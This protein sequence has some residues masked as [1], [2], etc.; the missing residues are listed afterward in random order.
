[1]IG[2]LT[3]SDVDQN[4]VLAFNQLYTNQQINSTTPSAS[5]LYYDVRYNAATVVLQA[6][7]DYYRGQLLLLAQA[8]AENAHSSILPQ[9]ISLAGY[10][11]PAATITEANRAVQQAA[12]ATQQAQGFVPQPFDMDS[13]FMDVPNNL[14][15]YAIISPPNV[16]NV[17]WVNALNDTE[18]SGWRL[19]LEA[20]LGVL[21]TRLVAGG[22]SWNDG[23]AQFGFSGYVVDGDDGFYVRM[24]NSE[25]TTAAYWFDLATG[26]VNYYN[27]S[28]NYYIAVRD[29]N[30]ET[31]IYGDTAYRRVTQ[32]GI[33]L[34]GDTLIA[35]EN[36]GQMTCQVDN[37][38]QSNPVD[39]SSLVYWTTSDPTVV[40]VSNSPGTLGKLQWI[41]QGG[42]ATITAN[43][44][45]GPGL[46]LTGS[47][48][49]T[50][51]ATSAS[52]TS[53]WLA[54][55]NT[56]YQINPQAQQ[57]YLTGVY[58]DGTIADL[59]QLPGVTFSVTPNA[60]SFNTQGTLGVL[61]YDQPIS[62]SNAAA[63]VTASYQGLSATGRIQ[64]AV[65]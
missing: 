23:L 4:I 64:L 36:G 28:N 46:N 54:P 37:T 17:S 47:V 10:T 12:Q 11:Q 25:G 40:T 35:V 51:T 62:S 8:L 65:P 58:S 63:T 19:P 61:N 49:V 14:M 50:N 34:P 48:S 39:I 13:L 32:S 6:Q 15:W 45:Q 29:V 43:Y 22:R 27:F 31:Y 52:L 56:Q 42:T 59:T 53:V 44:Y 33:Q 26:N 20:E 7:L 16:D 18:Y 30:T 55:Y 2:T 1:M 9:D 24:G 5:S 38:N 41:G 21:Y 3:D 60:G 57:F